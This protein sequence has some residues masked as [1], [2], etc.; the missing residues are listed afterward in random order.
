VCPY[1]DP[2]MLRQG[3]G[4]RLHTEPC[5]ARA[6]GGPRCGAGGGAHAIHT[7]SLTACCGGRHVIMRHTVCHYVRTAFMASHSPVAQVTQDG[8]ALRYASGELKEDRMVVMAAVR[9][10]GYSLRYA[11]DALVGDRAVVLVAVSRNGRALEYASDELKGDQ[12]VVMAA[13]AQSVLET[14][15]STIDEDVLECAFPLVVTRSEFDLLLTHS[16]AN[17]LALGYLL[18]LMSSNFQLMYF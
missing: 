8:R 14:R 12:D 10:N 5:L 4:G 3:V 15:N 1:A 17:S 18:I 16:G 6:A 7:H 13:L 9:Q 2:Y 11:S